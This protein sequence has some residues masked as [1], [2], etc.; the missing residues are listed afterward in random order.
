[1][2]KNYNYILEFKLLN[3]NYKNKDIIQKEIEDSLKNT[4][5]LNSIN[6][7]AIDVLL[8]NKYIIIACELSNLININSNN[9]IKE[10]INN[11]E[12][13]LIK[14][15]DKYI[16][17]S[18]ILDANV[19]CDFISQKNKEDLEYGFN[20]NFFLI[21]DFPD[22]KLYRLKNKDEYYN[23]IELKIKKF[24]SSMGFS[25]N[26]NRDLLDKL[27]YY[28]IDPKF[29]LIDLDIDSIPLSDISLEFILNNQINIIPL[30]ANGNIADKI[31]FVYSETENVDDVS[32]EIIRYQIKSNIKELIEILS[33]DKDINDERIDIKLNEIENKFEIG[34]MKDKTD[35]LK[36][37]A[38]SIAKYLNFANEMEDSLVQ[39]ISYLYAPYITSLGK[40]Y[41]EYSI[42]VINETISKLCN[43]TSLQA[44]NYIYDLSKDPNYL[45]NIVKIIDVLDDISGLLMFNKITD[46]D[47]NINSDVDDIINNLI[48]N[49]IDL[50]INR[51]IEFSLYSYMENNISAFDYKKVF[52][53]IYDIF[54]RRFS[55]YLE[56]KNIDSRLIKPIFIN[57]DLS[58]INI[59]TELQFIT[60][61]YNG[62]N[63]EISLYL[64]Y[65]ELINDKQID[66]EDEN[67]S[68]KAKD[69]SNLVDHT[70][71]NK[72][73][74][75]RSNDF[76]DA[77]RSNNLI[78]YNYI[79][80]LE[81]KEFLSDNDYKI[82]KYIRENWF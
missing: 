57:F 68:E 62:Y 3:L 15:F 79:S 73:N 75:I 81:N 23:S 26:I 55:L 37:V 42:I 36:Y 63:R 25:V 65:I 66:N 51:L 19:Y 52:N 67:I 64:Q 14:R 32:W 21:S 33:I 20:I 1:M 77:I 7:S 2:N 56:N 22:N 46:Y 49:M 82:Y 24:A 13:K 16:F 10:V 61:N 29:K 4:L 72:K 8:I 40:N 30:V 28:H 35:R 71:D 38:K 12:S 45:G 17:Y 54:S 6:Y 39:I 43:K 59:L 60:H 80:E 5:S 78:F 50:P 44:L 18:L 48:N 11:I 9:F 27:I 34:T 74:K 58:P 41:P 47:V 70:I 69:F 53:Q 76:L 31:I